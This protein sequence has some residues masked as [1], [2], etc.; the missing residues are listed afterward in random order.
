LH[1]QQGSRGKKEAERLG[2][3]RWSEPTPFSG[4]G[5]GGREGDSSLARVFGRSTPERWKGKEN[6]GWSPG[7]RAETLEAIEAWLDRPAVESVLFKV[8]R[9]GPGWTYDQPFGWA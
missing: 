4:G 5:V 3:A 1:A 2:D 9:A 6:G 8:C 7:T